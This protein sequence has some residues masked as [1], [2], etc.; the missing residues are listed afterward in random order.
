MRSSFRFG[1]LLTLALCF[2]LPTFCRDGDDQTL[3]K[4]SLEDLMNVTVQTA[5]FH[6]QSAESAPASVSVVTAEDIRKFG[7]RTLA[8]ALENVRGFY[9]SYDHTYI[10][11]GIGGF[12]PPGDFAT[13]I[14]VLINGHAMPENIFGSAN[15]FGD[16]FAL[17]MTLVDRIEIVRG[18]SSALYGSNGIFATINVIT[19]KPASQHGTTVRFDDSSLNGRK[20]TLTQ[21]V[22]LKSHGA[23][24]FSGTVFNK[25]GQTSLYLP[26]FNSSLTNNGVAVNMDGQKGY[27]L[28]SDITLGRWRFTAVAGSRDKIQPI[29]FGETIFNDRGTTATDERAYVEA[30]YERQWDKKRDFRWRTFYD[31][32]RYKG[33]YVYPLTQGDLDAGFTSGYDYNRERDSGDWVGSQILYS[34]PRLHGVLTVGG[35]VDF[36]IRAIQSVADI[37]PVYQA[38][39]Y[40]N[41]PD[42]SANGFVQQEWSVG[43]HW[44]LVTGGRFDY[45]ALRQN[46]FSPRAAI[47]FQPVKTTAF[48]L[49]YGRGFRNPTENELFFSDGYQ[50]V[51][52]P[53][54]HPERADS[55]E[56]DL[57]YRLND[58]WKISFSGYAM[59]DKDVIVPV[60]LPDG[61]QTYENADRFTGSGVGAEL[62]G[63]LFQILNIQSNFQWQRSSFTDMP[64]PPNSP[65]DV[66]NLRLSLPL[67][68]NRFTLAGTLHYVS[69]R[70]TLAAAQLAPYFLPSLVLN[71]PQVLPKLDLQVGLRN[72]FNAMY[73]DPVGLVSTVDSIQQP[74]RTVFFSLTTHWDK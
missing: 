55:V 17:D 33:N 68:P 35:G 15:Y 49:I 21:A 13:R 16:D 56:A 30:A 36:D 10:N 2:S 50:S 63:Q 48:K 11:P 65:R 4:L 45:D 66:G 25:S 60:Y 12:S 26:E 54:L 72:M 61:L 69:E 32:Y 3:D 14:L 31:R 59:R 42:H 44:S 41:E 22:S 29:S 64:V 57:D 62:T 37:I 52:N 27:R 20:L 38:S 70:R 23:M 43:S 9:F 24:L 1:S 74:G 53:N 28:F 39:L 19:K 6:N 7:Y 8:D 34:F 71:A 18:T 5:S 40:V 58:S 73:S 46:S 47:V 51:G 67:R